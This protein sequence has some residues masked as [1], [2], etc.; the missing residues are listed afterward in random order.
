MPLRDAERQRAVFTVFASKVK[1]VA[2]GTMS[3]SRWLIQENRPDRRMV[4]QAGRI[5]SATAARHSGL[6][7]TIIPKLG[8]QV[9]RIQ[10]RQSN[11]VKF[12]VAL[13]ATKGLK[14][15]NEMYYEITIVTRVAGISQI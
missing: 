3:R 6:D 7:R 8:I 1:L 15:L 5:A 10:R 2:N 13:E 12:K 4:G 11:Q 14:T 9:A